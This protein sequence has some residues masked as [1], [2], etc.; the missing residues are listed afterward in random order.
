[1]KELLRNQKGG[2]LPDRTMRPNEDVPI[3]HTINSLSRSMVDAVTQEPE[4]ARGTD[5]L[6]LIG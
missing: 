2:N 5:V 3:M 4:S 1:M 6:A